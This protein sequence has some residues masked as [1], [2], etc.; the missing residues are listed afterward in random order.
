MV[1]FDGRGVVSGETM[2]ARVVKIAKEP[3]IKTEKAR[4]AVVADNSE[5]SKVPNKAKGQG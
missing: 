4:K 1:G 3:E 5:E 2:K